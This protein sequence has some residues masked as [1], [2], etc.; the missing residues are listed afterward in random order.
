MNEKGITCPYCGSQNFDIFDTELYQEDEF[1]SL[2]CACDMC[3]IKF[4][5]VYKKIK[6]VKK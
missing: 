6:I 2:Y 3:D 5:V 1:Y 4:E